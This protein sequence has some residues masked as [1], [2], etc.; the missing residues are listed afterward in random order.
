MSNIG[1]HRRIVLV[2]I[3]IIAWLILP[4]GTGV[5]GGEDKVVRGTRK[6]SST[7]STLDGQ[8]F[9]ARTGRPWTTMINLLPLIR[10][11]R[12]ALLAKC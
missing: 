6:R 5:V 1:N 9:R 4:R 10:T 11:L 2:L 12:A 7:A 8:A 3:L